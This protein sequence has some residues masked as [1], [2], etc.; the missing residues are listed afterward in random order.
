[1]LTRRILVVDPVG[2]WVDRTDLSWAGGVEAT[3]EAF[4]VNYLEHIS[5]L[6]AYTLILGIC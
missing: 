5:F 4:Q 1:M 3:D 6:S 2:Y